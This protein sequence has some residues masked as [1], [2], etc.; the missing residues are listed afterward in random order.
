MEENEILNQILSE[1]H[2]INE[3]LYMN[4]NINQWVDTVDLCKKLHLSPKTIYRLRKNG[5]LKFSKLN[6]KI[7]YHVSDIDQMLLK[8]KN[9]YPGETNRD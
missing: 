1:L 8:N 4:N 7:F 9:F 5:L 6:G 3:K 2:K